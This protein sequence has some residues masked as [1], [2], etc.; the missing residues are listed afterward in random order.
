MES[1]AGLTTSGCCHSARPL[2]ENPVL[3]QELL[4]HF[5]DLP[6]PRPLVGD[7]SKAFSF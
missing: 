2:P 7:V 6:V 1:G 3:T 5:E 4:R